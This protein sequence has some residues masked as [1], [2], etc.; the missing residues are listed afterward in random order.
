MITFN[1]QNGVIYRVLH[2]GASP[3]DIVVKGYKKGMIAIAS[4]V[5]IAE[6]ILNSI[7]MI[8]SKYLIIFVLSMFYIWIASRVDKARN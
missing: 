4:L 1:K 3:Y 5:I 8:F 7:I 2:N 6:I